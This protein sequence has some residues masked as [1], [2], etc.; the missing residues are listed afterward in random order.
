MQVS[1][2]CIFSVLVFSICYVAS[3][4][5]TESS[6]DFGIKHLHT[7]QSLFGGGV[8][9]VD[10]NNDNLMD[11]YYT[12]G[13][14]KN[15]KLFLNVGNDKFIDY[16][17]ESNIDPI[18]AGKY[19]FG[20]ISG[21]VNNDGCE[22][23]FVTTH[24]PSIPNMLLLGDC[25]GRFINRA[26]E[27]G[28]TQSSAST[29]AAFL[30]FNNDGFLD[31]YVVNYI[32]ESNFI[33]DS[34]DVVIGFDHE[35]LPNYLYVNNGGEAF[36]QLASQYNVDDAG[37]GLAVSVADY[38]VDGDSD[39]Y[40]VNDFG[41]W[42]LP[43]RMYEN[44]DNNSFDDISEAAG[45]DIGMYGMGVASGDV[46]ADG[47]IDFYL[48]DIGSNKLMINDGENVFS[49]S[50]VFFGVDNTLSI[51]G[52]NSTSW[53][54]VF[55]DFDNDVDLDL[56]VANGYI[57]AAP[58][59]NNSLVDDNKLYINESVVFADRSEL[60]EV[61]STTINR[62]AVVSDINNDG[63]LDLLSASLIKS[64][65]GEA[66]TNTLLYINSL[67]IDNNWLQIDLEGAL[68]NMNAF[69]AT[70]SVFFEGKKIIQQKLSGGSHAS[71]N[72]EIL[73]FGLRDATSIDSMMVHWPSGEKSKFE[74][75]SANQRVYIRE[76]ASSIAEVNCDIDDRI[77]CYDHVTVGCMDVLA[78][79]YDVFANIDNNDCN[80]NTTFVTS[81][82]ENSDK[83]SILV[84]PNPFKNKLI[85][86]WTE[87]KEYD[88][89]N[90]EI[91]D[92]QGKLY[93]K[94]KIEQD[95]TRSEIDLSHLNNGVYFLRIF[96]RIGKSELRLIIKN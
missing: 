30:D 62:G 47:D 22:D 72:S 38:D 45:L 58:F 52:S 59:L 74:S 28:I 92:L 95:I 67:G 1:L 63:I 61:N 17:I 79:N 93:F 88:F 41:Q 96:N 94:S 34:T 39:I 40:V 83:Y 19:T 44:I 90:F 18:T 65:V 5:M 80:Y 21:D 82:E 35:C 3:A 8:L 60:Y 51:Q 36:S 64:D 77:L 76:N 57:P 66:Q 46:D 56:F 68:S 53:G 26:D 12:G 4:Q 33:R 50:A 10:V 37:C 32:A 49:D 23:I 7:S 20:A 42:V 86:D 2:K 89:Q 55:A 16:S 13:D 91:V 9:S 31:I 54:A 6:I 70:V 11:L 24:S 73:Q 85:I 81:I 29:S 71:Q 43:N 69:G 48:T 25:S 75:V 87:S 14:T 15:D 78:N 27:M 84:A